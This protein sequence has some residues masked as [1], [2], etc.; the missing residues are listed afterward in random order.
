[1]RITA[2]AKARRR[3]GEGGEGGEGGGWR[4]EGSGASVLHKE[5]DTSTV[6]AL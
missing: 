1:M 2:A 3:R 4:V 5:L 6:V